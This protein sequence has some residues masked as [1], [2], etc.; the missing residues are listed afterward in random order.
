MRHDV[1][2]VT[3]L[4]GANV[5]VSVI[6]AVRESALGTNDVA[7]IIPPQGEDGSSMDVIALQDLPQVDL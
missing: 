5:F 6:E 2:C 3:A 7:G 1:T 4:S